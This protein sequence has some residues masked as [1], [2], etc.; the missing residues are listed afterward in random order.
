MIRKLNTQLQKISLQD[1]LFV[2]VTGA[3][4]AGKT[5]L[6]SALE[7][8]I[9][10]QYAHIAFF[11]TIGVPSSEI[12]VRD[13]GSAEKWQEAKTHEWVERLRCVTGKKLV[14]LEGQYNPNFVVKACKECNISNYIIINIHAKDG[15]REERLTQ[16]RNQP[17]LVNQDM[18]NWS[19]FLK[20]ETGKLDGIIVENT[21]GLEAGVEAL[22][23]IIAE[24]LSLLGKK[25]INTQLDGNLH[26]L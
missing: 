6:I 24:K 10:M 1:P 17:E 9:D 8:R 5:S 7:Q 3:S 12:M 14:L 19:N 25:S 21:N 13:Y 18:R 22:S 2:F 20:T 4:G 16:S 23:K 15:L 11:D 26:Q